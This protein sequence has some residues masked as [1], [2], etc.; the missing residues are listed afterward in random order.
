MNNSTFSAKCIEGFIILAS[1]ITSNDFDRFIKLVFNFQLV[2]LEFLQGFILALKQVYI[3][4]CRPGDQEWSIFGVNKE[5]EERRRQLRT[6]WTS[7]NNISPAV[8][9]EGYLEFSDILFYKGMLYGL[10]KT[11]CLVSFE[12][13]DSSKP[14]SHNISNVLAMT[15]PTDDKFKFDTSYLVESCGDLLMVYR[16]ANRDKSL[17]PSRYVTGKF[18]VYKLDKS[19]DPLQWVEVE[20]LGDQMLFLGRNSSMSISAKDIPGLK[21]NCIYFTED[22]WPYYHLGGPSVHVFTDNGVFYLDDARFE[23]FLPA[24]VSEIFSFKSR[25]FWVTPDIVLKD[26]LAE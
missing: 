15:S 4:M 18:L 21:G 3:E 13:Q 12:F 9:E 11:N 16:F 17:K 20:S 19:D 14:L 2:L 26:Y 5:E 6:E 1:S 24:G 22:F 7:I 10:T 25:P 23:S 8:K